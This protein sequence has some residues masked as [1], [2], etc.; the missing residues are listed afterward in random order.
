MHYTIKAGGQVR[1]FDTSETKLMHR[2]L[3]ILN[4]LVTERVIAAIPDAKDRALVRRAKRE[5]L[6]EEVTD[7]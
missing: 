7:F 2:V 5:Q 6:F 4:P 3:T 1:A